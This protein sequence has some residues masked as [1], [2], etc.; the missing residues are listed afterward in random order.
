MTRLS[1]VLAMIAV[2][3][4][5]A[6]AQQATPASPMERFWVDV[7][8]GFATAGDFTDVRS[9]PF[10]LETATYTK[11]YSLPAGGSFD[12]GGGYM[13]LPRLGAGVSVSR[14]SHSDPGTV[15]ASI[16]HPLLF[17]TPATDSFVTEDLKRSE[18]A[19]HLQV[20][21]KY[22]LKPVDV[23]VFGGPSWFK[24]RQDT[25]L[26]TAVSETLNLATLAHAIDITDVTTSNVEAS[27]WGFHVG[28][29]VRYFFNSFVGVGGFA[30]W[31]GANVDVT[32]DPDNSMDLTTLEAGGFQAGGG[33]RTKF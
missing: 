33:L 6:Y 17:N 19:L 20:L 12:V 29:D 15:T 7:N 13:I 18:G 30:R 8:V 1:M 22:D 3:A 9:V 31:S 11:D 28:G 21:W 5:P 23:R 32:D 26:N 24:V 16:P 10:R 25:I 14:V 27:G 4:T 2:L